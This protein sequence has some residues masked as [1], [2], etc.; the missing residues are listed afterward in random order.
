MGASDG[1][2]AAQGWTEEA[3]AQRKETRPGHAR[4]EP[5]GGVEENNPEA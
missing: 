5:N 1:G 4:V 3:R 2:V